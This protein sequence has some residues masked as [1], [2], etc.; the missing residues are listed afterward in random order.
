MTE[1]IKNKKEQAVGCEIIHLV[2]N[3]SHLTIYRTAGIHYELC[4]QFIT[5]CKGQ[6]AWSTKGFVRT[7]CEIENQDGP[8]SGIITD[9]FPNQYPQQ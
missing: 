2:V 4:N 9:E 6:P 1:T 7:V 5:A 8:N 3:G